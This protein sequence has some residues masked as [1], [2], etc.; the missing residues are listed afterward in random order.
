MQTYTRKAV[1]ITS[2]SDDTY[3]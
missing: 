2:M 3:S 1:G